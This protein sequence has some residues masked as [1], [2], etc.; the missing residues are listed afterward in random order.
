MDPISQS[1]SQPAQP[2][3]SQVSPEPAT[4][5]F[6][7]TA[8]PPSTPPSRA[9]DTSK[10]S[11]KNDRTVLTILIVFVSIILLITA[12]VAVLYKTGTLT[13]EEAVDDATDGVTDNQD[14]ETDGDDTETGDVET[15]GDFTLPEVS[16]LG[17]AVR[18]DGLS[19]ELD[20]PEDLSNVTCPIVISGNITGGWFFEGS[21]PV[22]IENSDGSIMSDGTVTARE[23]ALTSDPVAF[24][25]TIDCPDT[26]GDYEL[27][28][29]K[30]NPSG[31][32]ENSDEVRIPVHISVE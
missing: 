32:P 28:L 17:V 6:I 24:G 26:S 27:V 12:V 11:K 19:L 2:V 10:P 15:D 18:S 3:N 21:L 7:P 4:G 8:P 23:D 1:P 14:N 5:S 13:V 9:A 22:S 25:A 20:E 29:H 16:E 31:L 30:S